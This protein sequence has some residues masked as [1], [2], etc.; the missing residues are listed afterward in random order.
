MREQVTA[1][2]SVA[3]D[4]EAIADNI[5][6]RWATAPEYRFLNMMMQRVFMRMPGIRGANA[7]FSFGQIQSRSC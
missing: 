1:S 3:P 2:T 4:T 7:M 6:S 5:R